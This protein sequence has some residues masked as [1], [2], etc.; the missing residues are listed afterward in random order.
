VPACRLVY[1]VDP[2]LLAVTQLRIEAVVA[3]YGL[4][5]VKQALRESVLGASCTRSIPDMRLSMSSA[6][7]LNNKQ[8]S[9]SS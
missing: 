7:L 1:A 6:P 9:L 2:D 5:L 4:D 8:Y 3:Y